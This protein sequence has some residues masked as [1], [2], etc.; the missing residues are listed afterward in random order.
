VIDKEN[1]GGK[2]DATNAGINA[3]RYPIF[4]CGD[5]DTVLD[6]HSLE[7]QHDRDTSSAVAP[8]ARTPKRPTREPA[9]LRARNET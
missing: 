6:P 7:V 4:Y 5:A 9:H 1:G 2:A 3:A 8:F